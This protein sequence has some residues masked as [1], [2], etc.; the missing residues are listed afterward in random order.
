MYADELRTWF[1]LFVIYIVDKKSIIY[2]YVRNLHIL[3]DTPEK[4][5]RIGITHDE[6]IVMAQKAARDRQI[7][8]ATPISVSKKVLIHYHASSEV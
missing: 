8:A 2:R 6:W 4:Q 1:I 5:P 7:W 3:P